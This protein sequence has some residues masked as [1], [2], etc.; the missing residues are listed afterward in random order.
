MLKAVTVL[1]SFNRH[2]HHSKAHRGSPRQPLDPEPC[3]R[4]SRSS[5]SE[6]YVWLSAIATGMRGS[7]RADQQ[8]LR[9]QPRPA[10]ASPASRHAGPRAQAGRACS[11]LHLRAQVFTAASLAGQGRGFPAT[12]G[13][14]GHVACPVPNPR[15]R[16]GASDPP[17]RHG[18]AQQGT[19]PARRRTRVLAH[20]SRGAAGSRGPDVQH[21]EG[22]R[23]VWQTGGTVS[24]SHQQRGRASMSPLTRTLV[25]GRSEYLQAGKFKGINGLT[26]NFLLTWSQYS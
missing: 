6:R 13:H 10:T 11:S 17:R 8:D 21:L 4:D 5:A 26:K 18:R 2:N 7:Q 1:T 9:R 22:P 14:V 16:A 19:P 3:H 23:A 12:L 25:C 24:Q 15:E 20:F